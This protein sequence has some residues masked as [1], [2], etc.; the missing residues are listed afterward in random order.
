MPWEQWK[1]TVPGQSMFHAQASLW[2]SGLKASTWLC[3]EMAAG[4]TLE[5]GGAPVQKPQTE[6]LACN[7]VGLPAQCIIT[8][9]SAIRAVN[10]HCPSIP[11][12]PKGA[13]INEMN[14]DW[15]PAVYCGFCAF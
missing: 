1:P 3:P 10:V 7:P 5:F 9:T 8:T 2:G 11:D 14:T 6:W 15:A 13:I 12:S 4:G